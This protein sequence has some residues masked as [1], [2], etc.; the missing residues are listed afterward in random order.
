[1]NFGD[2]L[3]PFK[4]SSRIIKVTALFLIVVFLAGQYLQ[5]QTGYADN[6][7][8]RRANQLFTDS[9]VGF[10]AQPPEFGTPEHKLR[11]Y[12]Y[13]QPEWNFRP[14][15]PSLY[16]AFSST[17]LLWIPGALLN[18]FFISDSILY[19]VALSIFPRLLAGLCLFGLI[20]Y[21]SIH[22]RH[23]FFLLVL[24]LLPLVLLLNTSNNAAYF[25]SFYQESGSLVYFLL[26]L[27]WFLLRGKIANSPWVTIGYGLLFLTTIAK[28]SNFY[29]PFLFMP[30]LFGLKRTFKNP[31]MAALV[32]A[33]TLL[34]IAFTITL[35]GDRSPANRY[36]ALFFGVLVS[37][38]YP[39]QRLIDI[40]ITDP[41][42]IKCRGGFFSE[43]SMAC[44][45][46]YRD[47]VSLKSI[48]IFILREPTILVHHAERLANTMQKT[49]NDRGKYAPGDETH[50]NELL[51]NGWAWLKQNYFPKGWAF[52]WFLLAQ[53][54]ITIILK[55]KSAHPL[56][57]D[58]S[59]LNLILLAG[60]W[61]DMWIAIFGDGI[62]D[63]VKHLF[64][65][66]LMFDLSIFL[67]IAI[68]GIA[69]FETGIFRA[70]RLTSA[71]N[72]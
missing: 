55:W 25:N 37:S 56:V 27:T 21:F 22:K 23:T 68:L 44:Y 52:Y 48:G 31:K 40:G 39:E 66:N 63:L 9:P 34:P 17:I 51:Y 30:V 29:F 5:L 18:Y 67:T 60:T 41:D 65:A 24:I 6:G 35:V 72:G 28:A 3:T 14:G 11:Y 36:N 50:R 70:N 12:H 61:L 33:L 19:M 54:I 20:I 16:S 8:F 1:M 46:K 4:N 58:F 62:A 45:E 59:T 57:Q 49:D 32:L 42:A 69:L 47:K 26:L 43:L 13:W 38:K 71:S 64:M 2:F 53:G 7:D 10:S 15:I